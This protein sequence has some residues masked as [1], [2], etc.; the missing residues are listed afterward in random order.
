MSKSFGERVAEAKQ[1]VSSISA[2]EA[3][4]LRE[5]CEPVVFVDPRPADAIASTTGLIPGAK[6]VTLGDI[7]AGNLP[8]ELSSKHTR[9]FTS[10]QA[11]PMGAVAAHELSKLGYGRVQYVEGGTQAWLDAGFATER[12]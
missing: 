11:G 4:M 12:A 5:G 2:Q 1:A 8:N 3:A 10:C 9:V 7:E 6:N